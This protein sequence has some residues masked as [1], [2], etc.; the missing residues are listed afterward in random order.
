[1]APATGTAVP[2]SNLRFLII[3]SKEIGIMRGHKIVVIQHITKDKKVSSGDELG[4]RNENIIQFK[5]K[6]N[7]TRT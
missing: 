7:V 6:Q 4:W 2:N 3:S 5:K 1:M